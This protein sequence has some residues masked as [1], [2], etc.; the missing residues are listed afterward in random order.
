MNYYKQEIQKNRE[1]WKTILGDEICGKIA[2]EDD[3][4]GQGYPDIFQKEIGKL[5]DLY[6]G[7]LRKEK[8]WNAYPS[9]GISGIAVFLAAVHWME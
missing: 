3:G 1:Y 7:L 5:E 8:G 4:G 2:R 6:K 9:E